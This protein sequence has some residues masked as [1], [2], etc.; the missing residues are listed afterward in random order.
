MACISAF[1]L[2][3]TEI[4]KHATLLCWR[5]QKVCGLDV[6]VNDAGLVNRSECSEQAVEVDTHVRHRHVAVVISEVLVLEE[7]QDRN[8]LILVAE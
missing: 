3:Q 5:I 4:H 8:H 7:R 1:T 6:A 2:S